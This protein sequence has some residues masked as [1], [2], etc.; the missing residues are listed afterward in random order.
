MK[1]IILIFTGLALF[2]CK[3]SSSDSNI[4]I[5]ANPQLDSIENMNTTEHQTIDSL[6]NKVS[7]TVDVN[8]SELAWNY[9]GKLHKYPIRAQINYGEGIQSKGTGA[10]QIPITGYYYYVSTNEKIQIEG[11]CNGVGTIYFVAKTIGGNEYFDG[12]FK[13]DEMLGDFSGTWTKDEK[14]LDFNLISKK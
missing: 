8:K 2:A 6:K 3:N 11:S 1:K 9:S 13:E 5:A 10:L 7:N 4:T 14:Q 12:Q